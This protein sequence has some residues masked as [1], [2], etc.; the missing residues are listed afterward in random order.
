MIFAVVPAAGHSVRMGRPKLALPLG[1]STILEQVVASVRSAGV[2]HVLVVV[3]PHVPELRP[4][5]EKAGAHVLSLTEETPDMRATVEVGL[6]WL[7]DRFHPMAADH[8]LL[9]PADHPTLDSSVV[10]QLLA[11]RIETAG[12]SI[13]VPTFDGRRGHPTLIAWS[14]VAGIRALLS[15]QG[16][17]VYLRRFAAETREV[18]VASPGILCDLDTPDDYARL[19]RS[20]DGESQTGTIRLFVY[21]TLMRGGV[22]HAVLEGQRFLREAI[23]Q[24]RYLLFDLGDYPGLVVAGPGGQA[25]YGELYDAERSLLPRLD[26]IEGAPK[27]YGLETVS[28][29]AETDPVYAYIYRQALEGRSLCAGGRWVN[30]AV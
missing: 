21:G 26:A 29:D 1:G 16:L 10:G 6:R 7:D 22:R 8:W 30:R 15:G 20:V 14:H 24:P 12:C 17:N 11:A 18:A 4:L 2:Q 3:G 5:A 9:V 19:Q 23:T 28:I 13:L 27:L 25:V